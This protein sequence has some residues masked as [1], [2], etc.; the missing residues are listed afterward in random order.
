MNLSTNRFSTTLRTFPLWYQSGTNTAFQFPSYNDIGH[1]GESAVLINQEVTVDGQKQIAELD[2]TN[3][4]L[5]PGVLMVT[6]S[7]LFVWRTPSGTIRKL[8][9]PDLSRIPFWW[10]LTR[11]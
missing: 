1:H 9:I 11:P 3:S 10:Y 7:N 2:W 4:C 8:N 5:G 6:S